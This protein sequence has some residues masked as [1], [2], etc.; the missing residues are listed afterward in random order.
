VVTVDGDLAVTIA[1]VAGKGIAAAVMASLLQGMLH[2]GL[3]SRVPLAEIARRANEFFCL[4]DLGARYAT[5]AIVSVRADGA[6]EYIN[7]G[8][9]PPLLVSAGGGV[10]RLREHNHPVGLLPAVEYRSSSFQLRT[11]DHIFLVTD[12]VTDAESP[13]G[14]FFGD[15]RLESF[16]ALGMSPD[17]LF[18][19]VRLFCGCRPLV[20]DCTVVGVQYTGSVN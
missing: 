18:H 9:V 5:F 3:Q 14:D 20:D 10:V 8:H 1:D 16:V 12:G 15:E 6:L 13:D 19:S 2:E 4:R 7:C 17:Q 11:R